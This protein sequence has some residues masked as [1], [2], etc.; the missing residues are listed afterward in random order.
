MQVI[1][2]RS[3]NVDKAL[4]K[5]V[6]SILGKALGPVEF[7]FRNK[8]INLSASMCSVTWD[9]IFTGCQSFRSEQSIPDTDFVV[10]LTQENNELNWFSA[11]APNGDAAA[12]VQTSGWDYY[13]PGGSE[14]A[15]AFQVAENL[16]QY[17]MNVSSDHPWHDPPIGCINDM[18]SWKPDIAYKVRTADV[19]EECERLI[20]DKGVKLNVVRQIYSILE[21]IRKHMLLRRVQVVNRETKQLP[22]TAAI[23]RRKMQNTTEPFRKFCMLIDHFD[24]LIRSA[25]IACGCTAYGSD[26]S[27]FCQQH[28]LNERPSL[29]RWVDALRDISQNT[30]SGLSILRQDQFHGIREVVK[31]AEESEMV[32]VRNNSRGHG[33]CDCQDTSYAQLFAVYQPIVRDVEVLLGSVLN[34]RWVYTID[35]RNSPTDGQVVRARDLTGDH[36]DFPEVILPVSEGFSP[37]TEE[38][39]IIGLDDKWHR[40]HP[41][42]QYRSCPVCGYARV[43]IADGEY[44]LDP[45]VGHRGRI[46]NG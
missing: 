45:Y 8:A 42:V 22:F 3:T 23:T 19:C 21:Y 34:M 28:S 27:K 25:V 43:L 17:L 11:V 10:L 15:I 18:C 12:F 37:Y 30:D 41:Y 1:L 35:M 14:Y 26:F 36:P 32:A 46:G 7:K 39:Y 38:V 24:S 16:F 13:L 5:S 9:A 44:Y 33:Y 6:C 2:L 20:I 29:G 40:L 31:K 4:L